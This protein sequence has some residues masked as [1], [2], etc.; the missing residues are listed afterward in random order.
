M[1]IKVGIAD[2]LVVV[3]LRVGGRVTVNVGELV[4][5]NVGD[6]VGRKVGITDGI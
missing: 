4:L 6:T 2:G 3:G 1:G 5:V